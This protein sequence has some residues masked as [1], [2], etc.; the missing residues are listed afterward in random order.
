M[1]TTLFVAEM[2]NAGHLL[3]GL[4]TSAG[5]GHREATRNAVRREKD[6]ARAFFQLTIQ[7]QRERRVGFHE[8]AGVCELRMADTS[9]TQ[10]N[11]GHE[12]RQSSRNATK[13][14]KLPFR[15]QLDL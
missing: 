12:P 4:A 9:D 10:T 2:Q 11:A 13:A 14:H 1:D 15:G 6:I 3:L 7:I 8:R 5:G